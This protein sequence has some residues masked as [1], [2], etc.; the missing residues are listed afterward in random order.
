MPGNMAKMLDLLKQESLK[1]TKHLSCVFKMR[2]RIYT[3]F[4][5]RVCDFYK[6]KTKHIARKSSYNNIII[7]SHSFCINCSFIYYILKHIA[8]NLSILF[9]I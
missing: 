7:S 1:L 2:L 5:A 9:I 4:G 8:F 3:N 6:C